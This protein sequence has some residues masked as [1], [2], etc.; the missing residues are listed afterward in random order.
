MIG[1]FGKVGFQP[2]VKAGH[3]EGQE[4]SLVAGAVFGEPALGYVER[5]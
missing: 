5:I 4:N 2:T 1:A 3:Q